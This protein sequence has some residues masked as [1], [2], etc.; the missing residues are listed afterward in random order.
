MR[1]RS[2]MLLCLSS[3]NLLSQPRLVALGKAL[4]S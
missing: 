4:T 3:G 2:L 1:V